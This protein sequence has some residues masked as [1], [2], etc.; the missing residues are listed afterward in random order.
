MTRLLATLL[1]IAIAAAALVG[2]GPD[3]PDEWKVFVPTEG[4]QRTFGNEDDGKIKKVVL[5]Y[6]K[7]KID[8]D[9]LRGQFTEKLGPEG[10]KQLSECV[11]P[12]GTSSAMYLGKDKEVFQVVISLLGDAFYDVELQRAHGLP[13][14]KL[15]NPETCKYTDEAKSACELDAE[16]VCKFK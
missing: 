14:V 9:K 15:P 13:G 10:F 7:S 3:I 16:Q 6:D 11:S 1:P 8:G 12:N 5:N 2:C 4:L